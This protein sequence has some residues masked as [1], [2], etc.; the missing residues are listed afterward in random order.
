MIE[1]KFLEED[2]PSR[3]GVANTNFYSVGIVNTVICGKNHFPSRLE[4]SC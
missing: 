4:S 3:D 1:A 2:L